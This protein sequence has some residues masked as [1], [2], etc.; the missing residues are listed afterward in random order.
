MGLVCEMATAREASI[1]RSPRNSSTTEAPISR[2]ADHRRRRHLPRHA[3]R[4]AH[5]QGNRDT[6]QRSADA[7]PQAQR[8]HAAQMKGE[9]TLVANAD[10][11][12]RQRTPQRK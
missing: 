9:Q 3:G 12:K 11:A 6:V 10:K 4:Q 5:H 2:P 1:S 7:A 8:R